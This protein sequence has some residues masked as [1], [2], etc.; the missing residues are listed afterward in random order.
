MWIFNKKSVIVYSPSTEDI[1]VYE[2]ENRNKERLKRYRL[3][4]VVYH[5]MAH[6]T[7]SFRLGR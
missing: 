6:E 7:P 4:R 1:R 3:R 5:R 2:A